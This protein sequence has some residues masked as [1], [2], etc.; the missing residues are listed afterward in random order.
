M[1]YESALQ[2]RIAKAMTRPSELFHLQGRKGVKLAYTNDPGAG[3]VYVAR[4]AEGTK[5]GCTVSDVRRRVN[6][7]AKRHILYLHLIGCL[8]AASLEKRL[9]AEFRHCLTKRKYGW[10]LFY[11]TDEEI[12]WLRRLETYNSARLFH[13]DNVDDANGWL[14]AI[15]N[16]RLICNS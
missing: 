16:W 10:E 14:S 7:V 6:I 15:R 1:F 12:G 5:I 9:H 2:W 13:F 11:L 8:D 3:V 4:T